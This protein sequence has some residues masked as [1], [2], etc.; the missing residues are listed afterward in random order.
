MA[1][2]GASTPTSEALKE[3]EFNLVKQ[4][5]RARCKVTGEDLPEGF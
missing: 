2:K 1:L 5:S 3:A 4:Y